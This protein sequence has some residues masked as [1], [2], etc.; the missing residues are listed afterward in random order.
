[1]WPKGESSDK[2]LRFGGTVRTA[3]YKGHLGVE[4]D[5]ARCV[6]WASN[7]V[8]PVYDYR[9]ILFSIGP[10]H[11]RKFSS[12]PGRHDQFFLEAAGS[13]WLSRVRTLQLKLRTVECGCN[14]WSFIKG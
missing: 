2:K 10:V 13:A 12:W 5:S 7:A 9:L 11:T 1:M 8:G 4:R 6:L 3:L 14:A